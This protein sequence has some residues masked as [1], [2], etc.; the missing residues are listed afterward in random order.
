MNKVI[1]S[2]I[3][4]IIF[5]LNPT[6]W[7]SFGIFSTSNNSRLN[8]FL[9]AFFLGIIGFSIFP[10]GDGYERFLAFGDHNILILWVF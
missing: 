2:L 5:I 3:S 7:F 9:L 10:W 4:I 8:F 1:T 6:L